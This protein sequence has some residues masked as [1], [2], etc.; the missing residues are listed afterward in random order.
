VAA[1]AVGSLAKEIPGGEVI[2]EAISGITSALDAV[3]ALEKDVII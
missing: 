3:D 1:T 2:V